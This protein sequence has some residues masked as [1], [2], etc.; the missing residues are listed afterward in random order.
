LGAKVIF[1]IKGDELTQVHHESSYSELAIEKLIIPGKELDLFHEH[2]FNEDLMFI[3]NQR[4]LKSAFK[5]DSSSTR[6]DILAIDKQ[7]QGVIIEIKKNNGYLGMET[8]ALFYLSSIA[9]YTGLSFIKLGLG[10]SPTEQQIQ[11]VEEFIH[12]PIENLNKNSRILLL[13][14]RFNPAVF[15]LGTWLNSA[16]CSF[17]AISYHVARI[18]EEKFIQFSTQFEAHSKDKFGLSTLKNQTQNLSRHTPS[19]FWHNIGHSDTSW[20]NYLIRSREITATYDNEKSPLCRG[21]QIM[22]QYIAGDIVFAFAGGCGVV[23]YGR[24]T[25]KPGYQYK[26]HRQHNFSNTNFHT[27]S[28]DWLETL[29]L[30]NAVPASFLKEIGLNHPTQTK[31]EIRQNQEATDLLVKEIKQCSKIKKVA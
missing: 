10:K 8:Q 28:I 30:E 3:A 2:I 9:P 26:D 23:G 13:A 15:S 16:Q 11:T 25:N 18:G 14:N 20:W 12:S 6:L 27:H 17:K 31:Q 19:F 29:D 1:K 7:G 21:F 4:T 22:N 5:Q 24:I